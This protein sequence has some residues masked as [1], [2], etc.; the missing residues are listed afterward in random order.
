MTKR[1]NSRAQLHWGSA[2]ALLGFDRAVRW[3][4]ENP[5]WKNS[6]SFVDT[7]IL[8]NLNVLQI[9]EY[10]WNVC[11]NMEWQLCAAHHRLS[12]QGRAGIVFG[13][14]PAS[15]NLAA[16]DHLVAARSAGYGVDEIFYL[17]VCFFAAICSNRDK[18][19][20]ADNAIPSWSQTDKHWQFQCEVDED[21]YARLVDRLLR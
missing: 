8:H 17:E 10:E 2:P 9:G 4:C 1:Q 15:L 6:G 5:N 18:L 20:A 7:C 19:F 13:T 3:V 16:L 21:G 11:K 12:G 14:L